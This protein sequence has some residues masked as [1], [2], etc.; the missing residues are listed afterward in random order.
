MCAC[1]CVCVCVIQHS[2]YLSNHIVHLA[3]FCV[4]VLYVG[5]EEATVGM[6]CSRISWDEHIA[7]NDMARERWMNS[8]VRI[9]EQQ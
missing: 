1:V 4:Q 9:T 5:L 6:M 8:A 3:L 2:A 7:G